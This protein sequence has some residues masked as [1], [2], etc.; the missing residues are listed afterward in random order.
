M[1][2]HTPWRPEWFWVTLRRVPDRM[3]SPIVGHRNHNRWFTICVIPQGIHKQIGE[4]SSV[5]AQDPES[6]RSKKAFWKQLCR[7]THIAKQ[8][9]SHLLQSAYKK[10]NLLPN[11]VHFICQ[12]NLMNFAFSSF[13]MSDN[14]TSTGRLCA[15]WICSAVAFTVCLP[16]SAL[17][18]TIEDTLC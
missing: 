12:L 1:R 13:I 9:I 2:T 11:N 14:R 15:Q 17:V 7:Q 18:T 16:S 6:Q 5:D 3:R 4:P 10:D 8:L